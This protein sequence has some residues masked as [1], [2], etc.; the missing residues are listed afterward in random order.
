VLV[1]FSVVL[2]VVV[3]TM[4]VVAVGLEAMIGSVALSNVVSVR[5]SILGVVA[6]FVVTSVEM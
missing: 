1:V 4:A 3:E 5:C 2:V 6:V